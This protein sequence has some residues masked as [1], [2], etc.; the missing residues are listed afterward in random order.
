MGIELLQGLV[1]NSI[2]LLKVY[3]VPS[4]LGVE[5]TETTLKTVSLKHFLAFF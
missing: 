4:P 2:I 3:R 5:E 1:L